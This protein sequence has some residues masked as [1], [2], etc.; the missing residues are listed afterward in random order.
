L[1]HDGLGA[2][3]DWPDA[4]DPKIGAFVY[5]GDNRRP[6]RVLEDAPNRENLLLSRAF[7]WAHGDAAA[8]SL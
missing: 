5:Y 8:L 7:A 1:L 3:A 6:H 4:L 2:E